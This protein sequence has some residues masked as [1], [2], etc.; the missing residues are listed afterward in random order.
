MSESGTLL[1]TLDHST[2][3]IDGDDLTVITSADLN[4]DKS[5]IG[6]TTGEFQLVGTVTVFGVVVETH[7][8]LL[9]EET[10]SRT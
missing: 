5:E 3:P 6:T 9:G 2:I 4:D 7:V 10:F 8:G 1:G